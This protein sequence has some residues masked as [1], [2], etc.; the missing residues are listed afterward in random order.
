MQDPPYGLD[1]VIEGLVVSQ[2]RHEVCMGGIEASITDW[3]QLAQ[4][5]SQTSAGWWQVNIAIVQAGLFVWQLYVMRRQNEFMRL[6]Q[7][8]LCHPEL[9]VTI[10]QAWPADGR[11]GDRVCLSKG[12][13]IS[14]RAHAVNIGGSTAY[15]CQREKNCAMAYVGKT[16]VSLPMFRPYKTA[17]DL[18]R[19]KQPD[20]NP[21]RGYDSNEIV[22]ELKPGEFGFWQFDFEV[23]DGFSDGDV[24]YVMGL[25]A[26]WDAKES[27]RV[28]RMRRRLVA[29]ARRFCEKNQ[30][31]YSVDSEKNPDYDYVE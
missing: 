19:L 24:L 16:D 20:P 4:T 22:M 13:K 11:P 28:P 12:K 17:S 10:V 6:Q 8:L 7:Q 1:G 30:V 21:S 14:I 29:F 31:F 2:E 25:V 3:L 23:A 27:G 15:L 18:A 5:S 26:C 9:K